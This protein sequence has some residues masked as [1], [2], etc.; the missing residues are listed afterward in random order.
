MAPVSILPLVTEFPAIAAVVTASEL[1]FAA[2]TAEAAISAEVTAFAAI[3]AVVHPPA[4]VAPDHWRHVHNRLAAGQ[5]P[6]PYTAA[7]HRAWLLR[8]RTGP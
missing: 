8:C 7:R 2:V 5:D 1:S 4:A 6:R 3:F